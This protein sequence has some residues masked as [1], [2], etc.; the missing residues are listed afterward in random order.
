MQPWPNKV[1]APNTPSEAAHDSKP[2]GTQ[3]GKRDEILVGA[4]PPMQKKSTNLE[5]TRLLGNGIA[6]VIALMSNPQELKKIPKIRIII[7]RLGP[8]SRSCSMP[9]Q[10]HDEKTSK[11]MVGH[12]RVS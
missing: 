10:D 7:N 8:K 5:A 9:R 11:D 2:L 12:R 1:T 4:F 6:V 3:T